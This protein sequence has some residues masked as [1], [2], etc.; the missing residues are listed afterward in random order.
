MTIGTS[1]RN[2]AVGNDTATDYPYGFKIFAAS[3]LEV[4]VRDAANVET[5]LV[6]PTSYSVSGV[7]ARSGGNVTLASLSADYQNVDGTLKT[8]Y[9]ITIRRVRPLTQTADIRNQGGFFADI[10]EDAFDHFVMIDQQQQDELDRCVKLP[11]TEDG[12]PEATVLPAASTRAGRVMAWDNNGDI[13]PLAVNPTVFGI[14]EHTEE[15]SQDQTVVDLSFS[16]LLG[17][18][19]IAVYV[20][21]LRAV[22]GVDYDETSTT[23][24]TFLYDL[25]AGQRI[26][27][28]GMTVT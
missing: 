23:K 27:V 10:H 6:Y 11:T 13:A 26:L 20:D 17:L 18:N 3:D 12:T 16:Y 8:G 21:G 14:Y 9:A 28:T 24:I 22:R 25:S 15:S 19:A 4:K 7:G 1:N 2:D 5:T